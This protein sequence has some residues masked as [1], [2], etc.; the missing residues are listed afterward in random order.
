MHPTKTQP[1]AQ[2]H[3][4]RSQTN[5][6][7]AVLHL[8]ARRWV[9]L[10]F[11]RGSRL[12]RLTPPSVKCTATVVAIQRKTEPSCKEFKEGRKLAILSALS[13]LSSLLRR[14]IVRLLDLGQVPYHP[15][16]T[17]R[18]AQVAGRTIPYHTTR[19]KQ[20]LWVCDAD[21]GAADVAQKN[22]GTP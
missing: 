2:W 7:P 14:S 13:S 10:Y 9:A 22:R 8:S 17:H 12:T 21:T 19:G 16:A 11:V 4:T 3:V 20:E 5:G 18:P 6:G 15:G 1:T